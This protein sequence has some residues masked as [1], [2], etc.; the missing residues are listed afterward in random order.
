[1]QL[2]V[3][4]FIGG[5]FVDSHGCSLIDVLN[6]VSSKISIVKRFIFLFIELF[7]LSGILIPYVS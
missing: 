5:K 4:N 6:P 7:L 2:K 3:P 1:M